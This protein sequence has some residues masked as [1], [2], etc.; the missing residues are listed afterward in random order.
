MVSDRFASTL[1]YKFLNVFKHGILAN[2]FYVLLH[3]YL[4]FGIS[5]LYLFSNAI[6]IDVQKK[7]EES[8]VVS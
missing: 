4:E 8:G 2:S 1:F 5:S 7:I 3:R 6:M